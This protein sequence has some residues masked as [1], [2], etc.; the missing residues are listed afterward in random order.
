M[1]SRERERESSASDGAG[2][3]FV[4]CPFL[5]VLSLIFYANALAAKRE[6]RRIARR[7]R[8]TSSVIP[9]E[10]PAGRAAATLAGLARVIDEREECDS[11]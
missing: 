1:T 8:I 7:R 4:F 5:S 2:R 9:G 6:N 10:I 11:I 3:S